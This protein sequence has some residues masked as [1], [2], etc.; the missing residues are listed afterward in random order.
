MLPTDPNVAGARFGEFN[1]RF[2]QPS[3]GA[4]PTPSFGRVRP[5]TTADIME[6]LEHPPRCIFTNTA[7]EYW[8]GDAS[9]AHLSLPARAGDPAGG[10]D[11]PDPEGTRSYLFAGT[12]HGPNHSA[13]APTPTLDGIPG[14]GG[15]VGAAPS[16]VL[17]YTP[18]L[19]AQLMNL[20]AWVEDGVEPPPSVHPRLS[21][22]TA[23]D[24]ADVLRSFPV[25]NGFRTPAPERLWMTREIDL[26]PQQ[27]IGVG[28]YPPPE[29]DVIHCA[30]SALD[31]DGNE[32]GGVRLP[33][34]EA[35]V[36]THAGWNPRHA[37]TSAPEQIIPMTGSSFYLAPTAAERCADDGRAALSERYADADQY[38]AIVR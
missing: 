31:A 34:L 13:A 14:D 33:D 3:Q 17:D 6:G 32:L 8:R 27:D 21:D 35:P 24:R 2:A 15:F 26:G 38:A 7:A 9:L 25:V 18:L 12:Q 1:H 11:L 20:V 19:R 23:Q 29:G 16:C 10:E 30:V 22:G 5:F 4:W 37:G 28:S 36:G